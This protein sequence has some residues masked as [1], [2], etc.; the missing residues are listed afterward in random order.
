MQSFHRVIQRMLEVIYR[1]QH[2]IAI[3]KPAG[4]LVHRSWLD[5]HEIRFVM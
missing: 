3:N 1:D 5:R 4:W 2:L